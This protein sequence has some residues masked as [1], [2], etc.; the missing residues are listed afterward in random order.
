MVKPSSGDPTPVVSVD[1]LVPAPVVVVTDVDRL[2]RAKLEKE[3]QGVR[4]K[5]RWTH[6][7]EGAL[8]E[9][10]LRA[11]VIEQELRT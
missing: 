10:T 3:L 1:A 7:S 11:T 6:L 2:R 9:L 8:Q 4:A 5:L